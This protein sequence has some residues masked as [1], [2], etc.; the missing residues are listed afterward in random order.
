[1]KKSDGKN[2]L[3]CSLTLRNLNIAAGKIYCFL[4]TNHSGISEFVA[5]FDQKS[6]D[7][8]DLHDAVVVSFQGQQALFEEELRKDESDYLDY[9]D[10]G[11]LCREFLGDVDK[12]RSLVEKFDFLHLLDQGYRQLSTGQSRKLLIL[13]A[14]ISGVNI[15]VF[16][17]P[18]DGLD[19]TG[20]TEFN[21]LIRTLAEEGKTVILA[22]TNPEDRPP[23]VYKTGVFVDKELVYLGAGTDRRFSELL[24]EL[25]QSDILNAEELSLV[26][27]QHQDGDKNILV[28]LEQGY[29]GYGGKKLFS[30][31]DLKIET[32]QHTLITGKNG[33]GKSTLLQMITGDN[34]KCYANRLFLF[35]R[36]RG[37]GESVWEIKERMGIVSTDL[38]R[39]YRVSISALH[40]VASGLYDSI[41]L[42]KNCTGQDLQKADFWLQQIGLYEKRLQSFTRLTFAEQRLV[43]IARALIKMPEILILDEPTQGL[44]T[45][46]RSRL[47]QFLEELARKKLSTMIYVSHR[48]D[49][50]R[51]FFVQHVCLDDYLCGKNMVKN[52]Q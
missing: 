16:E 5:I 50:Y 22:V 44:D 46:S 41:G 3:T 35:G 26:A 15:L 31:L 47:L 24:T 9:Q 10:P 29:A 7:Y 12:Y 36:R 2:E 27:D 13:Q 33:C 6:P 28:N 30:G 14:A 39:N 18:Y 20:R 11:T 1:M 32:G 37:T 52:T 34:P 8:P 51:D 25:Y 42:Y 38:H 49:E 48:Q 43:L 23:F 40:T 4:G 19:Q 17:N 21:L 45:A